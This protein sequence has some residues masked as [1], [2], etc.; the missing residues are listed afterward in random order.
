M[1]VTGQLSTPCELRLPLTLTLELVMK[2][3][4]VAP[5]VVKKGISLG[6]GL[7]ILSYGSFV[8]SLAGFGAGFLVA[9][10]IYS[11]EKEREAVKRTVKIAGIAAG[12]A[13]LLGILGTLLARR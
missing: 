9:Q 8:G 2:E 11:D 1:M 3:A 6:A 5:I 12:S 7:R 4:V 10:S 13:A